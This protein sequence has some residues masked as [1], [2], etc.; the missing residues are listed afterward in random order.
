MRSGL[1]LATLLLACGLPL[2]ASSQAPSAQRAAPDV[3]TRV[4]TMEDHYTA[5][6]FV[7]ALVSARRLCTWDHVARACVVA[8]DILANGKGVA[9]NRREAV[10]LLDGACK[11]HDAT[12][13]LALGKTLETMQEPDA[14]S[15]SPA[16]AY[17]AACDLGSREACILRGEYLTFTEAHDQART[18]LFKACALDDAQSCANL[19]F[20][21]E[22][23]MGGPV[24][25]NGAKAQSRKACKLGHKESCDRAK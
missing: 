17:G 3:E 23:G 25:A 13:C 22:K 18:A 1:M 4:K 10:L 5:G 20:Y 24:D 16:D 19:A 8:G 6:K 12:A 11:A 21:L 14:G 2:Q 7:L 9:A 15:R